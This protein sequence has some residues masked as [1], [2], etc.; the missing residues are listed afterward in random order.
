[1]RGEFDMVEIK[2]INKI[3]DRIK[4]LQ[5][6]KGCTKTWMSKQMGYNSFAAF[7]FAMK[8]L[9]NS[10]ETYAKFA[11]FLNCKVEELYEVIYKE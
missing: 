4:V 9:S 6:Q 7:D 11:Y 8:N 5:Q 1:M 3:P 2:I 10:L